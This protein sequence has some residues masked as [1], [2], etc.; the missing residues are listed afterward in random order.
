MIGRNAMRIAFCS[1]ATICF[2]GMA[3]TVLAAPPSCSS[4]PAPFPCGVGT[5]SVCTK[6]VKCYGDKPGTVPQLSSTCTQ[7]KCLKDVVRKTPTITEQKR[8]KLNPQ[9]EPPG[10]AKAK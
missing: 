2:L 3:Q 10:V 4:L 7:A 5:H 1:V 6:T 9:P 8:L